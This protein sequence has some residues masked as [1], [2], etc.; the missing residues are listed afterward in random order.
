MRYNQPPIYRLFLLISLM[1]INV[2]RTLPPSGF[3]KGITNTTR[4]TALKGNR[5]SRGRKKM[6]IHQTLASTIATPLREMMRLRERKN[7]RRGQKNQQQFIYV[8]NCAR[9][10]KII[11]SQPSHI[12]SSIGTSERSNQI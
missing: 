9:C 4:Y 8:K 2:T 7:V 3:R 10:Q 11:F 1:V 5:Y 12:L 6:Q